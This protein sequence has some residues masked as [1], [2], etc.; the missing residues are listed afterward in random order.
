M[1][2][3]SAKVL[4]NTGFGV[5]SILSN[6][7]TGETTNLT[8]QHIDGGKCEVKDEFV[9]VNTQLKSSPQISN[10]NDSINI[11]KMMAKTSAIVLGVIAVAV[12]SVKVYL[13]YKDRNES[14]R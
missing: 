7:Y 8:Y 12:I 4:Y 5:L 10:S 11:I 14:R 9:M 6:Q 13:R 3:Y 2:N 1:K